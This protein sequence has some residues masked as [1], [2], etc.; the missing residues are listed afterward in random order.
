M[1]TERKD[2]INGNAC[3]V[4]QY[5][6]QNLLTYI[7]RQHI[8][9][10]SNIYWLPILKRKVMCM[11]TKEHLILQVLKEKDMYGYEIAEKLNESPGSSLA[12]KIGTLYPILHSLEKQK[13]LKS[14]ILHCNGKTRKYYKLTN[15]QGG[16]QDEK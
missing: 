9:K 14:Y 16:V 11:K 4:Y 7:G 1:Y 13:Y 2:K 8:I 15:G 5:I 6:S 10:S 3:I 12:E